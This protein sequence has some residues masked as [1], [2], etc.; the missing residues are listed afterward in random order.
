MS[1][2][3][4]AVVGAIDYIINVHKVVSLVP[5]TT[6]YDSGWT[7]KVEGG[8]MFILSHASGVALANVLLNEK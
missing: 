8:G 1:F 5:T 6:A 7:L 2:V 3:S 4:V